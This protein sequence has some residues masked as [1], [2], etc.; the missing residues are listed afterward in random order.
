MSFIDQLLETNALPDFLIRIGIRRLLR[1]TL[2][3]KLAGDTESRRA[4]LLEHIAGLKKS[5]IAVQTQAANEQHYEVPTRFYQLC[6]GK[7][8][9]YSSGYWDSGVSTLDQAEERML[10]LTCSRAHLSDGQSILELG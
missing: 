3:E 8:L 2:A 7:R 4:T 6:L 10:G 5:P 9:K 1:Q